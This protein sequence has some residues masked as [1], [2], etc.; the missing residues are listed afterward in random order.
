MVVDVERPRLTTRDSQRPRSCGRSVSHDFAIRYRGRPRGHPP[1]TRELARCPCTEIPWFIARRCTFR[2]R[3][4]GFPARRRLLPS[5]VTGL[6]LRD[7]ELSQGGKPAPGRRVRG[8]RQRKLPSV[9]SFLNLPTRKAP[10]TDEIRPISTRSHWRSS[11]G[12]SI[13]PPIRH[14]L[15]LG[16]REGDAGRGRAEL[17]VGLPVRHALLL[18]ERDS[19]AG[20]G[21]RSCWSAADP[22]HPVA[23]RARG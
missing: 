15:L 13:G 3:Q 6:R 9:G 4:V 21:G 20:R 23:R 12:S 2:G 16:E 18:G 19:G 7:D 11:R 22:G 8:F 1:A 5:A 14:G 17:L 10:S